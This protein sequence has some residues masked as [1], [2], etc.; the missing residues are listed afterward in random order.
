MAAYGCLISEAN[1]VIAVHVDDV[2]FRRF[3]AVLKDA[4]KKA[5]VALQ[6]AVNYAGSKARTVAKKAIAE[7]LGIKQSDLTKPHRFGS[8]SKFH[9]GP[10]LD[11]I[12]AGKDKL[13]ATLRIAGR[14]IPVS[15]FKPKPN[16]PK[17]PSRG[18][19]KFTIGKHGT[20]HVARAFIGRGRAGD[21]SSAQEATS[22]H[23][24]VF[25]RYPG[26]KRLKI[27]ELKGPSIPFVAEKNPPLKQALEYDVKPAMEKE[28]DRQLD[29]IAREWNA[30]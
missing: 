19:V 12:K 17:R 27:Y 28:L 5:I 18:G 13:E 16:K 25:S 24:G 8:Q 10:A 21:A 29:L 3:E 20:T 6:R 22:G 14:R 7:E 2:Q 30:K 11:L 23:V 26:V 9:T 4:P 15:F 1:P